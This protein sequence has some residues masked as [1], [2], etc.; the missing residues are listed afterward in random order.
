MRYGIEA[1]K[2]LIVFSGEPGTGKTT[3]IGKL[4][5]SLDAGITCI[6][7]SDSTV[8]FT[9]LL[10]SI[11]GRLHAE[12]DAP[13]PLS[14][15][16]N[17]K[18]VLRTQRDRGQIV[19]LI[20]DN[21]DHLDELSLEYLVE[22]FFS[23]N[24]TSADN[25]NLLQVI[26]VGRPPIREK[27][28]HPW[29]RPLNPHL[30][31]LCNIEPLSARDVAAY[32]DDQLRA[33]RFPLALFERL[34]TDAIFDYTSG[35]P[36]L[37]SELCVRAVQ[38]AEG[39]L[40]SKITAETIALAARDIGL[41]EAWRSRRTN[42]VTANPPSEPDTGDP[43]FDF[44]R[45][46]ANTTDMLM[47]TFM[48]D[49]AENRMG[50]FGTGASRSGNAVKLFLPLLLVLALASWWQRELVSGYV[51]DWAKELK[52]MTTWTELASR[53]APEIDAR[54]AA[55]TEGATAPVEAPRFYRPAPEDDR[56]V[57]SIL[58]SPG[59][60]LEASWQDGKSAEGEL[61]APDN[62]T[63]REKRS[64][65]ISPRTRNDEQGSRPEPADVR[66][67]AIA[68]QV[69]KAIQNRAISG[70]EVSVISGTVFLQGR[71]AS[72]R[73]KQAAERAAN[74]VDGV[75]RVRNRLVVG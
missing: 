36:K 20:V 25:D 17:C 48:Q 58:S 70:V 54:A 64:A 34:A 59:G 4:A 11:S 40:A 22:T 10:R 18:A 56:A 47:Q 15:V 5:E 66:S 26:L 75:E 41:S 31:L 16:D 60:E 32:V 73:Q 63:G 50:W 55:R 12:K 45:S 28:L 35:N 42:H 68:N 65:K 49:P 3:L 39:P 57:N 21:A 44:A 67:K 30:G 27:L 53:A 71:V 8:N 23:A 1:R 6:V 29:L 14:M 72:E 7:E 62:L 24:P 9:D 13:D 52:A 33:C 46:E 74:A 19:C 43:S 51:K 61:R 69:Q 2:G 37:I 38:L